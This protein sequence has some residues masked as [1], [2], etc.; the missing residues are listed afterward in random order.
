MNVG[1]RWRGCG[2]GTTGAAVDPPCGG[3]ASAEST[4]RI[5]LQ[6][7]AEPLRAAHNPS[8]IRMAAAFLIE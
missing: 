3:A 8:N 2:Y 5:A 7:A 4:C 6:N 1:K